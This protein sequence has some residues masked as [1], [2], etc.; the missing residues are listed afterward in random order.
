MLSYK[1]FYRIIHVRLHFEKSLTVLGKKVPTTS[2][3]Q[4][5][6][7]VY[8]R[9]F[10]FS[11]ERTSVYGV[12]LICITRTPSK[13]KLYELRK[14][15]YKYLLPQCNFD[16]VKRSFVNWCIFNLHYSSSFCTQLLLLYNL[17]YSS[18]AFEPL[19]SNRQHLS[20]DGC[21]EVRGEIIRTVLCCIVY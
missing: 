6:L 7:I 21:L 18:C 1:R 11:R 14:S 9:V 4:F 2:D 19:P 12:S 13:P 17:S 15:H 3:L 16:A 5:L 20:Y 8:A 10:L